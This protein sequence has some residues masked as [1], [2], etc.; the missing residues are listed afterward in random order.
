[1]IKFLWYSFSLLTVFL[2]L[3]NSPINTSNNFISQN[4]V[5]NFS[6]N[7]LLIQKFII[8]NSFMFFT[9]T[10]ILLTY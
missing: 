5:M 1:M 4:K 2:I 10:I 8:F 9:L 3:I 6:S 7:Q